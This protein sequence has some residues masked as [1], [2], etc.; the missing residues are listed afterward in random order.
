MGEGE[1]GVKCG[2]APTARLREH[3]NEGADEPQGEK[4]PGESSF[5]TA[6]CV[7]SRCGAVEGLTT[8]PRNGYHAVATRSVE[9]RGR[10]ALQQIRAWR[11]S[12]YI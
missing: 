8:P 10:G 2:R 5:P 7:H 11:I 6:G 9:V 4:K 12:Q 3:R 1:R